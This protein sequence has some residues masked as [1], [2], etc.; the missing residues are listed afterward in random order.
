MGSQPKFC[1]GLCCGH[2]S[3]HEGQTQGDKQRAFPTPPSSA[4]SGTGS[5]G[6]ALPAGLAPCPELR[7][8]EG[9]AGDLPD[10]KTK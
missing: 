7:R 2:M 5:Q 10:G 3:T 8:P 1:F 9:N 6:A 4:A